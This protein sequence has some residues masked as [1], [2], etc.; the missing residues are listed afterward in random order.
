MPLF[1]L[2]FGLEVGEFGLSTF[3]ADLQFLNH[4]G[5]LSSHPLEFTL[6]LSLN[7]LKPSLMLLC[8]LPH[9]PSVLLLELTH[10]LGEVLLGSGL[11]GSEVGEV[12][13]VLGSQV[14]QVGLVGG[15]QV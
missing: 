6:V 15:S 7:L 3:M 14:V 8:H 2:G 12:G 13:L 10:H 4:L 1:G 11:G 5:V 9:L